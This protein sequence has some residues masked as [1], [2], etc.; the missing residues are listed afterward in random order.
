MHCWIGFKNNRTG[1]VV[2]G[3]P[4][5]L[6]RHS[7]RL[8]KGSNSVPDLPPTVREIH[9]VCPQVENRHFHILFCS[10]LHESHVFVP[11]SS[12]LVTR[13]VPPFSPRCGCFPQGTYLFLSLSCLKAGMYGKVDR[14]FPFQQDVPPKDPWKMFYTCKADLFLTRESTLDVLEAP[15]QNRWRQEAMPLL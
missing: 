9:L 12:Y 2:Y 10:V 15:R 3:T 5:I 6:H 14:S 13:K 4:I 1:M 8:I 7:R 11:K